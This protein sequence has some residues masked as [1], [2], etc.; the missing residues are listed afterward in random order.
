[1]LEQPLSRRIHP[2]AEEVEDK[3]LVHDGWLLT[4]PARRAGEWRLPQQFPRR[5]IETADERF[6]QPGLWN[7]DDHEL[8]VN[9]NTKGE[10]RKVVVIPRDW[11][12]TTLGDSY[13][14]SLF[15]VVREL[16]N[17]GKKVEFIFFANDIEW[18]RRLKDKNERFIAWNPEKFT[19]FEFI[20][21]LSDY[22]AFITARYHGA[23]FASILKK[24]VVCIE[25]EQKLRLVADLFDVGA[26]L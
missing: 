23:V 4:V 25:V 1:M 19:I 18:T 11:P 12:H 15:Q 14:D 7:V 21:M 16:R 26:R 13:T 10:I 3:S 17:A 8:R 24:P 22:D 6:P 5:R 2:R 9:C 20:K